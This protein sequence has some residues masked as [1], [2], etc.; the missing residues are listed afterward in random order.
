MI[1]YVGVTN[2]NWYRQLSEQRPDEVNF[3]S[4]SGRPFFYLN[5]IP[6]KTILLAVDISSVSQLF[7]RFLHG[8]HSVR[9]TAQNH[10]PNS[11]N[12]LKDIVDVIRL[13][14]HIRSVAAS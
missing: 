9:K 8:R 2:E 11:A 10:I 7:P 13:T 3:W 12:A 6:R 5:Y 1:M 4:P 14:V